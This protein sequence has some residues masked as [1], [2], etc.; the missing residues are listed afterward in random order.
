MAGYLFPNE[1]GRGPSGGMDWAQ[2]SWTSSASRLN[3]TCDEYLGIF[4]ILDRVWLAWGERC[5]GVCSLLSVSIWLGVNLEK[6]RALYVP[7]LEAVW[8]CFGPSS[9]SQDLSRMGREDDYE[10]NELKGEI[11]CGC[12]E[13]KWNSEPYWHC[14]EL[15][16]S[17]Y[18]V[19]SE[20]SM[21]I[22]HIFGYNTI[23]WNTGTQSTLKQ[24]T[25]VPQ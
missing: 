9:T 20:I 12:F 7:S 10:L 19:F 17:I 16:Q 15:H 13:I 18:F 22:H 24:C 6:A 8:R 14:N 21:R 4:I 1:S 11:F 23:Y 3:D 2:L 5:W 25:S